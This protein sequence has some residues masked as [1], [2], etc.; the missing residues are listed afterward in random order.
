MTQNHKKF[1]IL[2][3]IEAIS[4]E[5]ERERVRERERVCKRKRERVGE[6]KREC[7]CL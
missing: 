5:D 6:R 7:L 2:A 1:P 4:F 3:S